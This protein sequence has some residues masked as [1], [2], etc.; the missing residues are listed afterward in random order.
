MS[1]AEGEM[2]AGYRILRQLGSGGMGEVYLAQ[3]PRLPR[4]D[5]LKLL[6]PQWSADQEYQSRFN[7]EAD[8]A[9]TLWHPHIVGIHD[10]GESEGQ[11]WL[12]MDYV[13]GLDAA[14]LLSEQ[15]PAGMPH[16]Q[17]LEI[18][19]AIAGA[20]DYAHRQGLLHRDVKPANIMLTNADD[21]GVRRS[22]LADFGIARNVNDISGLTATNM[23]V[24]TVAYCAPEQLMGE[25]IDARA[26][27]YALAATAYHLL[28][29]SQLFPH[30]N[31]AVVI[32]R[33]LN[34]APPAL[35]GSRPELAALDPV[36]DV[37][38]AKRPGD[39]FDRCIDFARAL[40][41]QV[42]LQE[43]SFADAPTQSAPAA[44]KPAGVA[45]QFPLTPQQRAESDG[46]AHSSKRRRLSAIAVAAASV[47]LIGAFA[48]A[49]HPWRPRPLSTAA[50]S[51]TT[52][53]KTAP[54][55]AGTN[56]TITTSATSSPMPVAAPPQPPPSS[57]PIIIARCWSPGSNLRERPT[58]LEFGCDGTGDLQNMRWSA[59]GTEGADGTGTALET[60]CVPDC[61][62]GQRIPYPVVVHAKGVTAA[63]ASCGSDFS[64]YN[65]LVIAYPQR[66]GPWP[67]NT[68]YNGM[69]ANRYQDEPR[70]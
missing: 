33:H 60:D 24:G 32:G 16:A 22:L 4:R 41:D 31:P 56:S 38:L 53:E 54:P 21:E 63:P 66:T 47:L 46:V 68:T 40:A 12:S 55:I 8:L 3:H 17:A 10:R 45:S 19:T 34:A 61:A 1:L 11:L 69:P 13:D 7:L 65:T 50:T 30:S 6:P 5:A 64:F 27:Q 52:S 44:T 23:T 26:D 39:R 62:D 25:D 37:A 20:L 28:T 49:W 57:E 51:T 18:I 29:G 48:L 2:F 43:H 42:G 58:E 35:A 59:W 36:F 70:C 9:S 67:A 14:R 15:F